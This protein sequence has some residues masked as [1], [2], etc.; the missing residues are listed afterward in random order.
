MKMKVLILVIFFLTAG[1]SSKVEAQATELA[2]LALNIE[3]LAQF[4]Q[5]LADLKKGY[6][7]LSGGY[8]TIKDLSEGNF[9]LHKVFLD[10]LLE[11]SPTVK[12]YKRVA[13]IVDY[14][15]MLVKE[16]K[17]A[18]ARFKT[19]GWFSVDE[20][21]YISKVYDNLFTLSVKNLDDLLTVVTA[22]KL[23]MSDDERLKAIDKIFEDME[24]KLVFLRS[25]NNSNSI[26]MG[27]RLKESNEIKGMQ[28]YY[29]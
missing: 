23:R 1:L 15:I 26:L 4:K 20:L 28:H 14:Q 16:Y 3:K 11:V 9:N 10:G 7:I 12:K 5:I 27:Q 17:A 25:F 21:D 24:D 22:K 18:L 29:K 8:K 19:S 2:Q 6:E 13:D